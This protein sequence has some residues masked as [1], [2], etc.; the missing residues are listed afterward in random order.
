MGN[1]K[2]LTIAQMAK[3]LGMSRIAVYKKVKKGQM[4]AVKI[5]RS[6]AIPQKNI[7]NILGQ[8]L[9]QQDKQEIIAAVKKTVAEYGDVLKMLGSE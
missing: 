8:E 4:E 5:G 7:L 1:E 6:Y 9:K 2:Y 3:I